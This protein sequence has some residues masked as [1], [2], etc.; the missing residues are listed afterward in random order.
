MRLFIQRGE[1]YFCEKLP[2]AAAS[3]R[4]FAI[5][6]NNRDL[7]ARIIMGNRI[8]A[9]SGVSISQSDGEHCGGTC[10]QPHPLKRSSVFNPRTTRST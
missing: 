10:K 5:V 7:N 8:L 9:D 2:L 4:N 6:F 3:W 1:N